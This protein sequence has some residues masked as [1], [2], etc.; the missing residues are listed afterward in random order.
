M[1]YRSVPSAVLVAG[2]SGAG[3]TA[4]TPRL[5]RELRAPYVEIGA[6]LQPGADAAGDLR[7]RSGGVQRPA[8]LGD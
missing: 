5:G 7:R 6:P 1:R 8:S 4:L 3:K 2:T